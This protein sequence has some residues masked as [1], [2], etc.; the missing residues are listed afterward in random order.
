MLFAVFFCLIAI[1]NHLCFK[2]Y[3]YDLGLYTK[4]AYDYAHL[5]VC[6]SSIAAYNPICILADHFDLWLV[7]L[8]PL[9]LLAGSY[10]LIFAQ[11][12]MA[13]VGAVGMYKLILLYNPT[14]RTVAYLAMISTLCFFGLWQA[15]AFDYHSNM[16]AAM[17]LPWLL[18]AV[19]KRR[20][21]WMAT[22]TL[23][24]CIAK[25][26]EALWLIF[27][28][29]ALL[30]DYWK[31]PATR[32]WLLG[33]MAFS[34]VYLITITQFVMPS[35]PG[36]QNANGW[37]RYNYMG[38]NIKDITLWSISHPWQLIQNFFTD[39]TSV[40]SSHMGPLKRHCLILLL[41][42]GMILLPLK[43]NYLLMIIPPLMLKWLSKDAGFWGVT[44]HYN[45]EFGP[46]ITAGAFIV[47]SRVK[48][49]NQR[50]ISASVLTLCT[51]LCAL[52]TCVAQ[53][54]HSRTENVCVWNKQHYSNPNLYCQSVR[55]IISLIPP[56]ASV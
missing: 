36:S 12:V 44:F 32:R 9:V 24:I 43:P 28:F 29:A 52:H 19:K 21:A 35:L 15:I 38:N 5:H 31:Q 34:I 10:A 49:R 27:V 14:H 7:L 41:A 54:P 17:L 16:C 46:I 48:K 3:C 30:I 20:W 55:R 8:A 1:P 26:T 47:I 4:A 25:E 13:I 11:I 22:F 6:D 23:L 33:A 45:V 53:E 37:W 50:L 2:T 18:W 51:L 40:P 39:F 56:Q 42:S